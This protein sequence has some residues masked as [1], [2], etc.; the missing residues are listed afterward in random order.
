MPRKPRTLKR[1]CQPIVAEDDL[2]T[3]VAEAARLKAEAQ[4]L[5]GAAGRLERAACRKLGKEGVI[6]LADGRVYRVRDI[7]GRGDLAK[8]EVWINRYEL[9]LVEA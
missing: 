4:Q 8:K 5:Y 9:E 3:V 1:P 7:F 6:E 2:R